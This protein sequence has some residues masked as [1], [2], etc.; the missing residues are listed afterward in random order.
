MKYCSKCGNQMED[1]MMF[2]QKCGTKFV[3]VVSNVQSGIELKL[4]QM[5]KYNLV[6]DSQSITWEYLREDGER[7]GN[8]CVKQ[9]KL[10]E[11]LVA[12]IKEILD[13]VTQEDKDFVEREVYTFVLNM[14]IIM[15]KEGE[16][17]FSNYA[18]LKELFDVGSNLVH[19][20]QLNPETFLSQMI[21]QDYVYKAIAGLQGLHSSRI[22]D[23]LDAD[24]ISNNLEYQNLTKQF[25]Q[26]FNKMWLACIKR[27]TD[28]F[29]SPGEGFINQ[30]WDCYLIILKGLPI[31]VI[32]TLDEHGWMIALDYEEEK[33]NGGQFKR[34]FLQKREQYR[35]T[36]RIAEKKL[37]DKEYWAAH[38]EQYKSFEDNNKKI[39][40]IKSKIDVINSEIDF[41]EKA[42]N[43][44]QNNR[45][46]VEK[47]IME[48]QQKIEILKNKIFGKKKAEEQ[49]SAIT[50]EIEQ[51]TK[52][53]NE[54]S[55][56]IQVCS[57]P[58]L[59]KKTLKADYEAEV[60]HFEHENM[61]LRGC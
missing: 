51:H 22:K 6:L 32:D 28:F 30:N 5:K 23:V 58:L 55:A 24:V 18:G 1:D 47:V 13:S 45:A 31:T 60:R 16:K 35:N 33:H 20:G 59:E 39:T 27:Y 36:M 8:I 3:D 25:A 43:L 34:T 57:E 50:S 9:D 44:H 2:C 19:V 41:I 37:K 14:G 7:A 15:C 49:I 4:A 40:E 61:R 26:A 17:L 53:L 54:I 46:S 11:E 48:K 29:T 38:S 52:E 21:Q 12:L 56:K 10:C 42:V